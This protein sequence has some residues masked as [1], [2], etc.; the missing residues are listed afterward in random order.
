MGKRGL[1]T[2]V[3]GGKIKAEHV[4][5]RGLA[6]YFCTILACPG[7]FVLDIHTF[8]IQRLSYFYLKHQPS[9]A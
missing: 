2:G 1:E 3:V 8:R 9:A 5:H 4:T 6:S 7:L